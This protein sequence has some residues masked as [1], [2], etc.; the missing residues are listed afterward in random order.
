MLEFFKNTFKSLRIQ[1][2]LL[3]VIISTSLLLEL[4]WLGLRPAFVI[5][6]V[7]SIFLL[8]LV[9]IS[10][11]D[12]IQRY[13]HS[14]KAFN[15]TNTAVIVV[16]V[17]IVAGG[18]YILSG[19]FSGWNV[20][21]MHYVDA[22]LPLR[23]TVLTLFFMFLQMRFWSDRRKQREETSKELAL[24]QQRD[25]V[26]IEMN[27]IQQQLKPHFLFNSLN[28]INALT[29]TNPEE[30]QKMVQL[31]SEFM[32][33]SIQQHQNE[34]V[35]LREEF[36][37]LQLYTEI[38]KVR[39]GDRLHVLYE[40]DE[41]LLDKKLPFLILQP[42]IENAIKYGLYGNTD[43][44]TITIEACMIENHLEIAVSNPFDSITQETNKG[45]GFGIRS[46]QRKL[47]LIY[48]RSNLLTTQTKNSI[49]TTT[50]QIPQL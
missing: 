48:Q 3:L 4:K 46:V 41:H 26:Q 27:S 1:A 25:M 39:F 30:A 12:V 45:T 21:Y 33:G 40:V 18:N 9:G 24:K 50:V 37:H 29:M 35:S 5:P 17:A 13:Y 23:I 28:S 43:Q 47:L 16:I 34:L 31:L 49:F 2:L 36:R 15:V 6:D 22:A 19:T 42:V 7:L 20:T 38:E 14:K 11:L 10:L 32:R 8:S 44:I